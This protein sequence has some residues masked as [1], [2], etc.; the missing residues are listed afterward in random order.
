MSRH[1]NII[2]EIIQVIMFMFTFRLYLLMAFKLYLPESDYLSIVC[3][4]VILL[5]FT[6]RSQTRR[7]LTNHIKISIT[8]YQIHFISQSPSTCHQLIRE[9]KHLQVS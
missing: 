6:I 5:Q 7:V 3:I 4:Q 9:C 2:Y 1:L 8:Y